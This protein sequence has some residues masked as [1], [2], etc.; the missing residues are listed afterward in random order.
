[1]ESVSSLPRFNRQLAIEKKLP[2]GKGQA[3]LA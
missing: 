2:L 1:M 3:S